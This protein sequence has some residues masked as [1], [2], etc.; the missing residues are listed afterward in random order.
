MINSSP[1]WLQRLRRR[2][3][4]PKSEEPFKTT[5]LDFRKAQFEYS[6]ALLKQLKYSGLGAYEES[7]TVKPTQ[8]ANP[9]I[10]HWF[11]RR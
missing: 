8:S 7:K 11:D 1:R 2:V 6:Q 10:K 4:N 5:S 3:A 9:T